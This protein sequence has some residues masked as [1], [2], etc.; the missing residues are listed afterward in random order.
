[1]AKSSRA[2]SWDNL[3]INKSLCDHSLLSLDISRNTLYKLDESGLFKYF[4]LTNSWFKCYFVP[5]LPSF[6]QIRNVAVACA[7]DTFYVYDPDQKLLIINI[8]DGDY[9]IIKCLPW[10]RLGGQGIM[11]NNEFH[12]I[13]GSENG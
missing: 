6:L 7:D 5:L 12:V 4:P 9:K 8:S 1:M 11:I 2:S 10:T 3:S 13:G